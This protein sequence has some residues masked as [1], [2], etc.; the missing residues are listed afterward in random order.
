MRTKAKVA[1]LVLIVV[2]LLAAGCGVPKVDWE[3]TVDGAVDTPL[4]LS[5]ADLAKMPQT[6][7]SEILM[8]RSRGEDTVESWSGVALSEIFDQAGAGT[9]AGVTAIAADGYAIEVTADELQNAIV[10]VKQNGEWIQKADPEHGPI[11]LVTPNTPANRWVFQL[12]EIQVNDTMSATGGIPADAALKITGA[13]ETEIGWTEDQVRAMDT[14]E[15]ESTNKDGE[16]KTYTGVSINDLLD[17]AGVEGAT[18]LTF[19]ADDGYSADVPLADVQA[20][21]DCIV[22]FRNQGG[23]STVLPGFPGNAQVKGVAEIQV[24]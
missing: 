6:D 10:A 3:L 22:S 7:L 11:R 17:K 8:Q 14:T 12:A 18:T 24:K 20:C 16:T 23:F 13:V 15:A 2:A 9:V 19:V 4:T 5:F 21:A 1:T